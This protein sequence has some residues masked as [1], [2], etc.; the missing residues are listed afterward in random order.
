LVR[1]RRISVVCS[2]EIAEE[3][4]RVLRLP[5][6]RKYNIPEEDI[7]EMLALLAPFLPTVEVPIHIRDPND[8]PVVAAAV[9]G[10]VDAIVT[11]DRDLLDESPLH[12]WLQERG[13]RVFT[14]VDFL[15]SFEG[16]TL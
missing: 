4:T 5:K 15:R 10:R 12:Q 6:L 1:R 2:W 7:R 8:A 9:A 3:L 13:I 11:G 16:P 14:P